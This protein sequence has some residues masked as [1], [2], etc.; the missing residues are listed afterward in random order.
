MDLEGMARDAKGSSN[1]GGNK[2]HLVPHRS[3]TT[4]LLLLSCIF[5]FIKF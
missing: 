3:A 2:R 5:S 1:E 4:T